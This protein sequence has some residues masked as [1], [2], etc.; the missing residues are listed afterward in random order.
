MKLYL[1]STIF[2]VMVTVDL[3]AQKVKP[4]PVDSNEFKFEKI[5]VE[6]SYPGGQSAWKSFLQHH[7]NSEVPNNHGAPLGL[8]TV[9]VKFVVGTDG[10]LADIVTETNP[11][12]GMAEEAIRVIKASGKW[13]P[14]IQNGKPVNAYRRQP[15]SFVVEEDGF[16]IYS[17]DKYYLYTGIDNMITTSIKDVKDSDLKLTISEGTI[18][19]AGDGR[20]LVRVPTPGHV[21]I[22]AYS[23]KK[24]KEL[25]KVSFEV[26]AK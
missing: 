18:S 21:I 15:L 1:F 12:Y 10:N 2:M 6:A 13:N 22:T 25:G 8:Y 16:E 11:G 23:I 9:V 24:H 14:A 7:L 5:E 20:F 4:E 19:P 3:S 17:K 26:R